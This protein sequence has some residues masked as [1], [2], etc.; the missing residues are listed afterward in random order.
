MS[1]HAQTGINVFLTEH[2][3][4]AVLECGGPA[5]SQGGLAGTTQTGNTLPSSLDHSGLGNYE[6]NPPPPLAVSERD[7]EGRRREKEKWIILLCAHRYQRMNEVDS[8]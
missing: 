2:R 1:L 4:Q 3:R 8:R 6:Q 7:R 5:A